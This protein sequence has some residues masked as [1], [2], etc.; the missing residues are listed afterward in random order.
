MFK[1]EYK[2]MQVKMAIAYG[3]SPSHQRVPVWDSREM[4]GMSA[5]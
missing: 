3:S 4:L 2:H 1:K 5:L